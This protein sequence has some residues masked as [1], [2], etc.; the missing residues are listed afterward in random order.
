MMTGSCVYQS[1]VFL[2]IHEWLKERTWN[3]ITIKV[4]LLIG[5]L[6][7]RWL[8]GN[9]LSLYSFIVTV[10]IFLFVELIQGKEQ[11]VFVRVL[12]FWVVT[13][14]SRKEKQ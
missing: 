14:N 12:S 2:K 3:K 13:K 4:L 7:I 5:M 1:G 11:N 8:I 9:K 6:S 10:M